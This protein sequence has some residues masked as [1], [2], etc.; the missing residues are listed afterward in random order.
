MKVLRRQSR[1]GPVDSHTGTAI[2]ITGLATSRASKGA[3]GRLRHGIRHK[4]QTKTSP[5]RGRCLPARVGGHRAPH[6][7][8]G[9]LDA[10]CHSPALSHHPAPSWTWAGLA[11]LL[12]VRKQ[13]SDTPTLQKTGWRDY[14]RGGMT[15]PRA[16]STYKRPKVTLQNKTE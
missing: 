7:A 2:D 13:C 4:H 3:V 15:R 11:P 16:A 12:S 1:P 5:P 9:K 10:L 6:T 14:W 8:Q